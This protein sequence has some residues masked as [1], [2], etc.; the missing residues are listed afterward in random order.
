VRPENV[1]SVLFVLKQPG[2]EAY[3]SPILS[4]LRESGWQ[5]EVNGN[6][7][8]VSPSVIVSSSSYAVEERQ[9]I[10]WAGM[11]KVRCVQLID[12]WYDY[13]RRIELTNGPGLLPDEIWLFDDVARKSAISEGLPADRLR[14]CGNPAWEDLPA[15]PEAPDANVLIVDQPINSDMG[16]RL[17]YDEQDF[18]QLVGEGLRGRPTG[19]RQ[20]IFA[21]HPRRTEPMP[22]FD[23]V[24]EV[25]RDARGA[26]QR[27]G[28]VVGMFSSLLIDAF[29]GGRRVVS[30]QP[31]AGD[32]DFC[33]LSEH[34]FVQRV[35]ATKQFDD[36]ICTAT[37]GPGGLAQRFA[38]SARRVCDALAQLAA[39]TVR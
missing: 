6:P 3:F 14:I 24:T 17:G 34:G 16:D 5:V 36:A 12:S 22:E 4:T 9:A 27:C 32:I 8:A 23:F 18:L 2:A 25:S 33:F 30:V 38:G 35:T 13:R 1:R 26:L 39:A 21:A 20:V 29:L 10:E 19:N 15:L 7:Q 31:N 37:R 11:R 28:T